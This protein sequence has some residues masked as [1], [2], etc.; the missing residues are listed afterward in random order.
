MRGSAKCQMVSWNK[1]YNIVQIDKRPSNRA[2]IFV[3]DIF[4]IV[5]QLINKMSRMSLSI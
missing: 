5:L 2:F 3:K 1:I 4:N